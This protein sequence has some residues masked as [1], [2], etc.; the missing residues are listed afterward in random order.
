MESLLASVEEAL[1]DALGDVELARDVARDRPRATPPPDDPDMGP[2]LDAIENNLM[3]T[4]VGLRLLKKRHERSVPAA[5]HAP[6][7]GRTD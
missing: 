3:D 5:H 6:N 7:S 1:R 2:L 4:V